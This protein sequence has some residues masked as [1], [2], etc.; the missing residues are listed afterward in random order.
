M[1]QTKISPQVSPITPHQLRK[2]Y[3][4]QKNTTAEVISDTRIA[5]SES[6]LPGLKSNEMKRHL[7]SITSAGDV[8][9]AKLQKLSEQFPTLPPDRLSFTAPPHNQPSK[10]V[11]NQTSVSPAPSATPAA[12]RRST[13]FPPHRIP[14]PMP[15]PQHVNQ[16]KPPVIDLMAPNASFLVLMRNCGRFHF[17]DVTVSCATTLMRRY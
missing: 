3:E 17:E 12:H 5:K 15:T 13:V 2:H 4:S 6:S 8:P 9:P 10:I 16:A 1:F 7:P 14:P 11:P